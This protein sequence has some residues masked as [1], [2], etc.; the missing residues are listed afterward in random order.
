MAG[1]SPVDGAQRKVLVVGLGKTGLSCA[2]YLRAA[3]ARVAVT[4]TRAQP[5][6]LER[7]RVE[8][9]DVALF[10]G[11]FDERAFEHADELVVSPGVDLREP[12]I[13]RARQRGVPVGG[14]IE[15]FARAVHAPVVA[16]T[17]S[18]GKSTVTSMVAAMARE[19]RRAVRV[20]GNLGTPVL[21]LLDGGEPD[22]YVLELSSFQLETTRSLNATAAAVLNFSPDHLDR[23]DTLE[24]YAGAKQ[25]IYRGDGTMVLNADDPRVMAMAQASRRTVRFTLAAPT[26]GDFGLR[27]QEGEPWLARGERVLMP[28]A[29]MRVPGRHNCANALAALALGESAGFSMEAMLGALRHFPGLAHRSQWVVERDGITWCNDSKATNVGATL[30]AVQ[31]MP[32]PVVLIAGGEGKGQDFSAL[33]PGLQGKARAV[34]LL[35]RDAPRIEQA[36]VGAVPVVRARDMDE[37]VSLAREYAQAGDVV[38]LSPA[39]ASFDMFADYAERG[40]RFMDAVRR[41]L[42]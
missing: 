20:G 4:D 14:D 24:A 40:E 17:G 18:N 31:G 30:A 1:V 29:R 8:L 36:L 23:H 42:A 3:G 41:L 5:P 21:E 39:C 22:L 34:V 33:R 12:P 32:D 7:L 38:L 15:L 19:E 25:R 9:P 28:V 10:L 16:I 13:A 11:G 27:H 26:D 6:G 37:A 35:G 2:R